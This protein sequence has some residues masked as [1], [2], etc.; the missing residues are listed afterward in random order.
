MGLLRPFG[1]PRA[2]ILIYGVSQTVKV[3]LFLPLT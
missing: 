2:A 1:S 3:S